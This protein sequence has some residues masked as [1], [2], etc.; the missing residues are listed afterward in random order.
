MTR[1]ATWGAWIAT[2]AL[3]GSQAPSAAQTQAGYSAPALYNSANA[4]ARAGKPGLAVLNYERARMLAPN[5]P[6]IDANL[7]H[8][9]VAAGL[10]AETLTRFERTARMGDPHI[11]SWIGVLGLI[12]AGAGILLKKRYSRHRRM[13]GAA[14]SLGISLVGVALCN[15]IAWWPTLDESVVVAHTAPARVSPVPMGEPLFV[16][17][18][19]EIVK[20]SSRHDSF[21]LVQNSAGR[22]GW[23]S[24]ENLAAVLAPARR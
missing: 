15:A 24:I 3:F 2:L 1:R 9:R 5:D 4:Y 12:V 7:R 18:E 20:T 19:A 22:Q 21:V 17:R 8:V 11:L 16:L 14:A 10:P 23:V 13:L 6:D